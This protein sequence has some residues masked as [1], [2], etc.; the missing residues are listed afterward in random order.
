M[1][2]KSIHLFMLF[3]FFLI[4]APFVNPLVEG[5]GTMRTMGDVTGE[6]SKQDQAASVKENFQHDEWDSDAY[7]LKSQMVPPVCPACPKKCDK[8]RE[9]PCPPCPPC[10]RCPEPAFDCK[11]VPNYDISTPEV[12]DKYLPK[13]ILT[14]FSNFQN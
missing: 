1:K 14:D 12:L 5:M 3:L 13:P 8:Q 11:K 9:K 4:I 2:L 10:A 6:R 7:A